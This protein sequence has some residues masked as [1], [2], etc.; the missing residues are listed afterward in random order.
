MANAYIILEDSTENAYWFRVRFPDQGYRPVWTKP[1]NVQ[2]TVTG[3]VDHQVG[4][5]FRR[6]DYGLIVAVTDP[7]GGSYGN[8][9]NLR[10]LY[11]LNDPAGSPSNLLTLTDH[12]GS[13]HDVYFVGDLIEAPLTPNISGAC[14]WFDV[15]ISLIKSEAE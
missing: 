9:A 15:R 11:Q 10:T 1:T 4:P 5:I 8:I 12:Y 2:Y 14:A 7:S 13:E 3:K 6:W